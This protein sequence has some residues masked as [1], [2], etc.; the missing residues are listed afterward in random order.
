MRSWM[1]VV[2]LMAAGGV[3]AAAPAV[4]TPTVLKPVKVTGPLPAGVKATGSLDQAWSFGDKNGINYV[5]FSSRSV[6]GGPG[7]DGDPTRG[8]WLYVDL[9]AV[10]AAGKPRLL[11]AVRDMALD[12]A[13]ALTARFHD[14]AFGVT[15]LD[16]DGVAEVSFAYELGCRSDVS[17]NT[18]KV[19]VFENGTKY[20]LRGTTR[21]QAGGGP[22]GDFEAEPSE[23]RWPR[24]VYK[25]ATELWQQ[26]A[27]DSDIPPGTGQGD[28]GGA[29]PCG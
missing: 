26:S 3:A 27:D 22:G 18:F 6:T 20:I 9:W 23:D 24:G 29:N 15:D 12:C 16:R 11:R 2:C 1:T 13:Y 7:P 5:L 21:I 28:D 4:A 19:L 14:D 17:A 25:R 10:P 8:A